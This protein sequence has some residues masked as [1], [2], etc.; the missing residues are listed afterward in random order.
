M[1]S[2]VGQ[3]QAEADSFKDTC[4]STNGDGIERTLLG[5]DLRDELR[6]C[7]H[8]ITRCLGSGGTYARSGTSEKDQ[9]AQICGA[10]VAQRAGGVD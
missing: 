4:E 3:E 8:I 2:P 10:L 5:E 1:G 7:K 9:T 6:S